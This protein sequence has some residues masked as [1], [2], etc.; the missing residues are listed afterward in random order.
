MGFLFWLWKMATAAVRICGGTLA[1]SLARSG[2][3]RIV[4]LRANQGALPT[5]ALRK[6]TTSTVCQLRSEKE[7]TE[8][9]E[10]ELSKG[11]ES[12]G[13][14]PHDR[15]RDGVAFH[16]L[17][18]SFAILF[19]GFLWAYRYAPDLN[20]RH[21]SAREAYLVLHE[22]EAA[23]MELIPRDYVDPDKIELPTDEELED[24]RIII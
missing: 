19:V 2:G 20:R 11:W 5:I 10:K 1:R 18:A 24:T 6:L 8:W 22:R 17:T 14:Y 15:E 23:N 4:A 12:T 16:M 7:V 13:M 3:V 9:V 21:W